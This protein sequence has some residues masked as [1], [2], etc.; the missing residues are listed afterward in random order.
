[1]ITDFVQEN[2]GEMDESDED[3]LW[4][5][6]ED[7]ML[8]NRERGADYFDMEDREFLQLAEASEVVAGT[9]R[10]AA[11]SPKARKRYKTTDP[12]IAIKKGGRGRRSESLSR[13]LHRLFSIGR[14]QG[15]PE[16][17]SSLNDKQLRKLKRNIVQMVYDD[18]Q[19]QNAPIK[20]ESQQDLNESKILRRW[21]VLAGI[22]RR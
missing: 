21:S 5:R 12:R 3:D 14:P 6:I 16:Y 17:L 2:G 10:A 8:S 18:L 11:S 19:G 4:G 15:R 7:W 9:G 22:N 1:M 20:Q 13:M